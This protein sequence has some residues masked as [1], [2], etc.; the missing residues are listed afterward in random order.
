MTVNVEERSIEGETPPCSP[1]SRRACVSACSG[2]KT[3]KSD[4]IKIRWSVPPEIFLGDGDAHDHKRLFEALQFAFD[5]I[6]LFPL[7]SAGTA[8]R[9]ISESPKMSWVSNERLM[10]QFP[11]AGVIFTSPRSM[12]CPPLF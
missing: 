9:M 5:H 10:N 11:G 1:N 2:S 6:E 7:I 8:A 4:A 3:D 12:N